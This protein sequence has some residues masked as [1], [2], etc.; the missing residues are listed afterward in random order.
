[1]QSTALTF[2]PSTPFFKPLNKNPNPRYSRVSNLS[3]LKP[4]DHLSPIRGLTCQKASYL[5]SCSGFNARISESFILSNGRYNGYKVNA[6][7]NP[8]NI[9]ETKDSSGLVR[10]LQ[11]GAMFA[12]WY[13][14]NI[15]FNIFNK[16]VLKVYAFP[17]TVTAFQL[18]CGTLII[19]VM[20]ASNLY[21]RPKFT[22]SQVLL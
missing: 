15:Y 6:T 3:S 13:L 1:M 21:H 17:A 5:S 2:S 16:Q 19:L 8:E 11:L 10:I 9:G 12:V 14:L 7:S 4:L 22:P 18:G 20:W